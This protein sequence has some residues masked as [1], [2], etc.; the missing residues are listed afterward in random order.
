MFVLR[1]YPESELTEMTLKQHLTALMQR[2]DDVLCLDFLNRIIVIVPQS[3]HIVHEQPSLPTFKFYSTGLDALSCDVIRRPVEELMHIASGPYYRDSNNLHK[4]FRTYK[5]TQ[6]AF[7][8]AIKQTRGPSCWIFTEQR[9]TASISVPSRNYSMVKSTELKLS[10]LRFGVKDVFS[11]EGIRLSAGSQSYHKL[12]PPSDQTAKIIEDLI[13]AGAILVGMTKN[14]QFANGEDPQ[15]WID[16]ACPW[17]PRGIVYC[18]LES[19]I[20]FIG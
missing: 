9:P 4:V 15:E 1:G 10:G 11:I 2:D 19:P 14:T 5:D 18:L 12:Y 7:F 20:S 13:S 16:Y 6:D 3:P 8:S 17:N